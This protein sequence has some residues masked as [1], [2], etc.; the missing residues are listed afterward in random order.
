MLNRKFHRASYLL[1]ALAL[2]G[3]LVFTSTTSVFWW[4][5]SRGTAAAA[6]TPDLKD[7]V[8]SQSELRSLIERYNADRGSLFR[9]YPVELSPAR[10]A[11]FK[12]FYSEWLATLGKLNFDTLS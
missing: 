3:G 7:L 9:S 10:Q 1:G 5:A 6:D 2:C 12:Q 4:G 8:T 11:R